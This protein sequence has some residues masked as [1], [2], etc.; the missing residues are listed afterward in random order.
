MGPECGLNLLWA[1][2]SH[3]SHHGLHQKRAWA[4]VRP[5]HPLFKPSWLLGLPHP[6]AELAASLGVCSHL[7]LGTPLFQCHHSLSSVTPAPQLSMVLNAGR[8]WGGWGL[9]VAKTWAQVLALLLPSVPACYVSFPSS[10]QWPLVL[11]PD[12]PDFFL[13]AI[14]SSS[15]PSPSPAC[16]GIM[17]C[18]HRQFPQ[19]PQ[20]S[21]IH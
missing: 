4:Q 1:Q 13:P 2:G 5:H 10:V 17:I 6:Q 16:Q 15:I 11:L 9:T 19:F 21:S 20:C 8:Q 14:Y 7:F 3:R 12:F 18:S